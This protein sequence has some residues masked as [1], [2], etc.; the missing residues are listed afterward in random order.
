MDDHTRGNSAWGC[1]VAVVVGAGVARARMPIAPPPCVRRTRARHGCPLRRSRA[2]WPT[3]AAEGGGV[4]AA[5]TRDTPGRACRSGGKLPTFGAAHCSDSAEPGRGAH[6]A[7]ATMLGYGEARA[8][9]M[10][11]PG[12]STRH[13]IPLPRPL[14]EAPLLLREG[15]LSAAEPVG[16]VKNARHTHGP[17]FALLRFCHFP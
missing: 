4:A 1:E 6:R 15:Y 8:A 14:L 11:R 16:S 12:K 2:V 9:R 10:R 3:C 5:L 17:Q 13:A 7:A